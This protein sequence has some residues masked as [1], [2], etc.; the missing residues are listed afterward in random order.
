MRRDASAPF[1]SE[2][3][4]TSGGGLWQRAYPV[5]SNT[6]IAWTDT[7]TQIYYTT[8]DGAPGPLRTA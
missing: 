3:A 7:A 8:W 2:V 6:H 1:G 4:L 5:I